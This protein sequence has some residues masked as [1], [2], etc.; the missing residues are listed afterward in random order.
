MSE[1]Y[2]LEKSDFVKGLVTT[3]FAAGFTV[4][5]TLT[6]QPDFNLFTVDW[7]KVGSNIVNVCTI[8]FM[9]YIMKNF[10]TTA[11]GNITIKE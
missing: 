8:T 11:Q 4:L 10:F 6:Q 7:V 2:T 5:F 9:S 1:L 3:L